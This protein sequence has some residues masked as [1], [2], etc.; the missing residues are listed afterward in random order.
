MFEKPLGMR[1][2]L[3]NL[4]QAKS[5]LR[6][7][8]VRLIEEWGYEMLETPTLEFYDTVGV[9][10]AILESQLFKLLDQQGETLVL[11]PDMTAPIARVAASKLY[12]EK[13]PLRLAYAA[14]VFR[15]QHHEG[16]RPAEF[17]QVGVELIGDKTTSADA[18]VIALMAYSLKAVGLTDFKI[19][20][21]HIEFIQ[22]LF[23]EVL[24][25]QQSANVLQQF[26]YEKNF[27]G[28]KEYV[29]N[30]S[31]SQR[32]KDRLLRVLALKGG[33]EVAEEAMTIVQ[34]DKG[35]RALVELQNLWKQLEAFG[36]K[37]FVK[38]E[39][40]TVSHMSYYTG[41]LFELYAERVG[42]PIGNGGRYDQLLGKFNCEAPATG[43]GIRLDRLLVPLSQLYQK[44]SVY[45]ILF[46]EEQREEAFHEAMKLRR[47]GKKVVMQNITG[48]QDIDQYTQSFKEVTY[49]FGKAG[50][51]SLE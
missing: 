47:E 10:S 40:H 16:G 12:K 39:L 18:E 6:S 49:F 36:V 15:A 29:K 17:E 31:L 48:I 45:G 35:R 43:F 21:G 27:V 26:L 30:L 37:S 23:E 25:N 5:F 51:E 41:I 44:Q 32:D 13:S 2:T 28:Y 19:S 20:I 24:G 33:I 14:N 8:M 3:P 7:E 22:A 34:S 50:K 46:S 9:Q 38:L 1:D 4:Y 11:R 42:L